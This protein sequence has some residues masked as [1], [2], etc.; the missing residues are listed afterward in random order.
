MSSVKN[1]YDNEFNEKEIILIALSIIY[2]ASC[3]RAKTCR[4]I[5]KDKS[6]DDFDL[7]ENFDD[8]KKSKLMKYMVRT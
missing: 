8:D 6:F 5:Y 3:Q 4:I 7:N 2:E 1:V